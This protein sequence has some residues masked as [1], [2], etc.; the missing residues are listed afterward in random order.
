MKKVQ[1]PVLV[2]AA[3]LVAAA[4]FVMVPLADDSSS[5]APGISVGEPTEEPTPSPVEGNEVFIKSE[6]GTVT[7]KNPDGAPSS[8]ALLEEKDAPAP[9]SRGGSRSDDS[10]EVCEWDDGEWDCDDA[11]D[12][13]DYDDADDDDD[14]DDDDED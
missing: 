5:T 2:G 1:V 8:S 4:A 3:G 13:D 11:D 14:D 12:D 7:R 9:A 6:D 10:H